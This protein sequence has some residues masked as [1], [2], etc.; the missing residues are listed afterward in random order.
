MEY[1]QLLT[2]FKRKGLYYKQ[3]FRDKGFAI[4]SVGLAEKSIN[5][6]EVF[7]ILHHDG[8]EIAG[9]KI[10]ASELY[11]GDA[12]FGATAY[13]CDSLDRAK[14]RLKELKVKEVKSKELKSKGKK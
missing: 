5:G 6:Y 12:Q 7:K 1:K 8:Y 10:E 9:N 3:V 2:D 11:A 13:F 4:Y 14:I